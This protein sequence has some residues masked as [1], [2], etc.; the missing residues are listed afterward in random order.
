ME[1][2]SRRRRSPGPTP[3]QQRARAANN[4]KLH[5]RLI[6]EQNI[7]EA[8]EANATAL[9]ASRAPLPSPKANTNLSAFLKQQNNTRERYEALVVERQ[10]KNRKAAEALAAEAPKPAEAEAPKS[11][12]ALAAEERAAVA[13]RVKARANLGMNGSAFYFFKADLQKISE[14]KTIY[15]H[16]KDVD[17]YTLSKTTG[18]KDKIELREGDT[19]KFKFQKNTPIGSRVIKLL[20]S[21]VSTRRGDYKEKLTTIL[22]NLRSEDKYDKYFFAVITK[23]DSTNY[24]FNLKDIL[25]TS[26]EKIGPFYTFQYTLCLD[27]TCAKNFKSRLRSM[28]DFAP[29]PVTYRYRTNE[30]TVGYIDL[31]SIEKVSGSADKISATGIREMST[32]PAP[33]STR[34]AAAAAMI[35]VP[36]NALRAAYTYVSDPR[37]RLTN[38]TVFATRKYGNARRYLGFNKNHKGRTLRNNVSGLPNAVRTKLTSWGET[39]RKRLPKWMQPKEKKVVVNQAKDAAA[40]RLASAVSGNTSAGAAATA[41]RAAAAVVLNRA[42]AGSAAAPST[43]VAAE[44][45]AAAAQNDSKGGRRSRRNR[46]NRRNNY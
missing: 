5:A 17:I 3:G 34:L 18:K 38:L 2:A 24:D 41:A 1:G 11:A 33:S 29:R 20:E 26:K 37:Q 21:G 7:R 32:P 35:K 25:N 14:P 23:F 22:N 36:V 43:A 44:E 28:D 10:E 13:A 19:I 45:A 42:G 39:L 27:G 12:E 4:V 6:R 40:E 9:A 8:A 46:R 31:E 16:G 15:E 30:P